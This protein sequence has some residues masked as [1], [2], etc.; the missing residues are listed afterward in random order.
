MVEN[1]RAEDK[2]GDVV[3]PRVFVLMMNLLGSQ[4]RSAK[5]LRHQVAVEEFRFSV[6][7]HFDIAIRAHDAAFE[8]WPGASNGIS[9]AFS[10]AIDTGR[11]MKAS[12]AYAAKM[13]H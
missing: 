12:A 10:G 5:V 4:Q 13:L 8:V 1:R 3:V 11:T 6:N 2:V 7:S 9:V